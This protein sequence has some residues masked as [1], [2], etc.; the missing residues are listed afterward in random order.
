MMIIM[1]HVVHTQKHP[2]EMW[3][4]TLDIPKNNR[5]FRGIYGR[6]RLTENV[7]KTKQNKKVKNGKCPH[8][9]YDKNVG[10]NRREVRKGQTNNNVKWLKKA[11]FWHLVCSF[12]EESAHT[13]TYS[14]H[15]TKWSVRCSFKSPR[16]TISVST[17]KFNFPNSAFESCCQPIRLAFFVP[18]IRFVSCPFEL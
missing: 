18:P 9:E 1:E 7:K 12:G 4:D 17:H 10:E 2:T 5:K 8:T 6:K 15:P 13:H 11:I 14:I 3:Y 16:T